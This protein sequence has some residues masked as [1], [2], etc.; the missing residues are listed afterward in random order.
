MSVKNSSCSSNLHSP[1]LVMSCILFCAYFHFFWWGVHS[2][3]FQ[4]FYCACFL[5][6]ELLQDFTYSLDTS[7]LADTCFASIFSLSVSF[8]TS[9]V[10]FIS[11]LNVSA[12]RS[13][14]RFVR[15]ISGYL[16]AGVI[17]GVLCLLIFIP[18]LHITSV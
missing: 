16:I 15:F 11:V 12:C 6:F 9:S 14:I 1:K 10:F 2:N 13:Y 5:I 17:V 18:Q 3:L 8:R 7:P 4:Y